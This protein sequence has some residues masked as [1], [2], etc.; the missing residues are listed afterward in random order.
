MK[1]RQVF[2]SRFHY[3]RVFRREVGEP[4]GSLRKRLLLERAACELRS[5]DT[6]VTTIAFGA[7]Y[8]SLEGFSRAFRC[9]Y[10]MSPSAYRSAARHIRL[11]PGI[12][13]VHYD[14]QTGKIKIALPGGKRNMDLI[15]RLMEKD[16]VIKRRLLECARLLT[17]RQL[18]APLA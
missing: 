2:L 7:N 8:R 16:Y 15:N 5:A 14:S 9:A 10:G 17:D 13:G 1:W 3:Q 4:P 18:D 12:S 11:L 6:V